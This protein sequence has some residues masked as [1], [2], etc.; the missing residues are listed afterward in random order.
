MNICTSISEILKFFAYLN[1]QNHASSSELYLL[2]AVGVAEFRVVVR[3]PWVAESKFRHKNILNE[4]YS[5]LNK[6]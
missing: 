4:K 2:W 6:F 3:P 5:V 1:P